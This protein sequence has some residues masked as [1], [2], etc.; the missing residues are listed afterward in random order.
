MTP[1]MLEE[2]QRYPL[3]PASAS[4]LIRVAGIAAAAALIDKWPGQE[5]PM[6]VSIN[7][8]NPYGRRLAQ[9]LVD[10]VGRNAAVALIQY[11]SGGEMLVPNLKIVLHQRAQQII[12]VRFD[13]MT[14]VGGLSAR[15]A[16]FE[17]GL[18]FNMSN[19]VIERIVNRPG[20]E[21]IPAPVDASKTKARRA[22]RP[23]VPDSQGTL[24]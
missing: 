8:G 24:F 13:E 1:Q 9:R 5:V 15:E 7:S 12:R 2:L 16:A 19:K 22:H 11:F 14:G 6:P 3:F 21:L 10:I 18:E 4:T 23:A 20:L 17:L